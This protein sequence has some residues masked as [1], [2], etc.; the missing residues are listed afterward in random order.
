LSIDQL[1]KLEHRVRKYYSEILEKI[2]NKQKSQLS[3]VEQAIEII[4]LQKEQNFDS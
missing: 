3:V 1:E 2:V 4:K